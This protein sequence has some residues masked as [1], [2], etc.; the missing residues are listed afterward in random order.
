MARTEYA[1]LRS[2]ISE[3]DTF[4]AASG[5]RTA[6]LPDVVNDCLV[7]PLETTASAAGVTP[8]T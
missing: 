7:Y 1:K 4:V 6:G 5:T 2:P 8:I 3:T